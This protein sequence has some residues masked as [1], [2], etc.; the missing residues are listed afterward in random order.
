MLDTQVDACRSEVTRAERQPC[1][2]QQ[3]LHGDA[4][5]DVA[6]HRIAQKWSR[7]Y[8][9][10]V[11]VNGGEHQLRVAIDGHEQRLSACTVN[12]VFSIAGDAVAGPHHAPELLGVEMQQVT[13][14]FAPIGQGDFATG[15]VVTEPLP[16]CWCSQAI[17]GGRSH[18]TPASLRHLLEHLDSAGKGKS[19]VPMEVHPVGHPESI[20]YLATSQYKANSSP[21][22]PSRLRALYF[23]DAAPLWQR[24]RQQAPP[25]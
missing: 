11:R 10:F 7:M 14:S 16:G 23:K 21:P 17:H 3:A 24:V 18:G 8:L 6:G 15:P 19:G 5:S 4:Q 2:R 13:R 9:L 20:G 12:S 25:R 22:Q 1:V